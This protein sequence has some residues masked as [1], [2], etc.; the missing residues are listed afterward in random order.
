MSLIKDL[1]VL[2]INGIV[3]GNA[4]GYVANTIVKPY[5]APHVASIIP[6]IKFSILPLFN[7][8]AAGLG[9]ASHRVTFYILYKGSTKLG[10]STNP[11]SLERRIVDIALTTISGLTGF[12]VYF[13]AATLTFK[14]NLI[15]TGI[16]VATGL[17]IV[18]LNKG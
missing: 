12:L 16:T 3:I 8:L 5:I 1:S 17:T 4:I 9:V 7:P 15:I 11:Q 2:G 18:M 10:I 14:A 13:A 6:G